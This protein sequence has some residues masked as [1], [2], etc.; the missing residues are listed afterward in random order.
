MQDLWFSLS[1]PSVQQNKLTFMRR[2]ETNFSGLKSV[3]RRRTGER[4]ILRGGNKYLS[5][6]RHFTILIRSLCLSL[7]QS[8]ARSFCLVPYAPFICLRHWGKESE[9]LG[10]VVYYVGDTRQVVIQCNAMPKHSCSK[11]IS[12]DT[13]QN[14]ICT[15][16]LFMML[17]CIHPCNSLLHIPPSAAPSS[18]LP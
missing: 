10:L 2:N 12:Y 17:Y 4:E 13:L 18:P 15:S 14:T 6:T 11:N 7:S 16:A 1:S 3:T 9:R 5:W 8:L